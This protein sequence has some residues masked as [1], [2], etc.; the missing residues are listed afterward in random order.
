[1]NTS[2]AGQSVIRYYEACI[3][4]AYPDPASP[5]ARALA[6]AGLTWSGMIPAG[7]L[8][9]SGKPWTVGIGDTGDDVQPGLVITQ[10][11]ANER[12]ARR[13][14]QEFEPGVEDV[15]QNEPEQCQFDAFVSLAFNIGLAGF[16]GSTVL[17]QFNL[18]NMQESA[19][20]FRMWNK[21]GGR[22]MLG[23]RRRRESERALFL[24]E[25]A[26]RAIAIGQAVR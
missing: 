2:Q 1:M 5:L 21:S 6:A 10:E 8:N 13:L 11:Q 19:D 25:A 24:G 3:L 20:A 15:L 7:M 22:V 16:R 17:R 4:R 12:F 9:L 18:G 23:L 26:A 14:A